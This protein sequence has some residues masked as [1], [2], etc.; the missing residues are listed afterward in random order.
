MQPL[1]RSVIRLGINTSSTQDLISNP[2][3]EQ[4]DGLLLDRGTLQQR[5]YLVIRQGLMS[6]HFQPGQKLLL[7]PLAKELGISVTPVREA[8]L[9]LVSEQALTT[10][11]SR[12]MAVP[13]VGLQRF[14]E[15]RDLR[16][17]LEGRAVETAVRFARAADI[18]AL[19]KLQRLLLEHRR[20]GNFFGALSVN[21]R[22]HFAVYRLARMP[23]LFR[24]VEGLWIQ[25]GPVL[26]RLYNRVEKGSIDSQHPH[27]LLIE[28]MR[29]KD[30]PAA[31]LALASDILWASRYLEATLDPE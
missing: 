15:I 31:K 12:S 24:I 4:T 10:E 5:A 1:R 9:Q 30:G 28:A 3:P 20:T 27:D 26:T 29:R 7:R 25:I 23:V 2:P 14:L 18:A 17:E 6:G 19:A 11:S 16:I 21:E 13:V 22:F 8:L